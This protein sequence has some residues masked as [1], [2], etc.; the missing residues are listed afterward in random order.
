MVAMIDDAG[1]NDIMIDDAGGNDD[2]MILWS[3][4]FGESARSWALS[5]GDHMM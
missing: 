3:I 1:G 2:L 4:G 5:E